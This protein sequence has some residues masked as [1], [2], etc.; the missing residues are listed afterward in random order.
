LQLAN[1]SY[2]LTQNGVTRAI[3]VKNGNFVGF[4]LGRT[5]NAAYSAVSYETADVFAVAGMDVA[6]PHATFA[7]IT[8]TPSTTVPSTGNAT[9]TGEF[10]MEYRDASTE[11]LALGRF[12]TTVNFNAGTLTGTGTDNTL[13]ITDGAQLTVNGTLHGAEFNG[14]ATFTG[15]G[16]TGTGT[17]VPVTGGFYGANTVAGIVQNSDIAGV[18]WGQ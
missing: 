3:G 17:N 8:G 16:L 4:S 9:Y 11:Q 13:T 7:G 5:S 18:F 15:Y 12:T 1:G 2:S 10:G 14:T 6:T